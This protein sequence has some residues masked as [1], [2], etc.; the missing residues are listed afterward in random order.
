MN[1]H[2]PFRVLP[3]RQKI[4]SYFLADESDVVTSLRNMAEINADL[5]N[6]I[7]QTAKTLVE[8]VRKTQNQQGTIEA[9][10]QEY[11]L[12]TDEGTVLMCLA[13]ALLRIPDD[14]T[15]DK[16]IKDKIIPA[17][18][19]THLGQSQS[20]FVNAST[21]GLMLT[22]KILLAYPNEEK[23]WEIFN[24][25]LNRMGEPVIR[26]VLKKAMR[27]MG[28]QFVME[29]NIDKAIARSNKNFHD[30]YRFSYDMLGEAALCTRDAERYFE[31]YV[32]ALNIIGEARKNYSNNIQAP[33][34]S[35]K[36]SA[37]HPRYEVAQYERVMLELLPKIKELAILAKSLDVGLTIDA[38]EAERL[39]IS[40]DLYEAVIID[41]E[42]KPWN[43]FGLAVQAYQKRAF[44][45]LNWLKNLANETGCKI[46]VRLVK[47]A[48]WDTEIKRAQEKGL[49]NYPVF[50]RKV[51]TDI[52]YTACAKF[53]LENSDEFYPQ[54]ATHNAYT[55]ATII[56]LAKINNTSQ[57]EF[58]RLHGMGEALY[59]H[60]IDEYP[61]RVYAPVGS[62]EDLLPYLVRRLLENGAN[63]SFVNRVEN[64]DVPIE[65][66]IEDPVEKSLRQ[67]LLVNPHI[68]LP[69]DLFGESRPN[70]NGVN[71]SDYEVLNKLIQDIEQ[72]KKNWSA[73]PLI[74][75]W[76]TS[77]PVNE[78]TSPFNS[79]IIGEAEN[80]TK[81]DVEKCLNIAS[82]H[83]TAWKKS[84][85]LGRIDIIRQFAELLQTHKTEL[86]ALCIYEA[87]KTVNDAI[88]EV[89]EAID[90]CYYYVEQAENLLSNPVMLPGPTGEDNILQLH[91]RGVFVCISPWNFPLAIFTGQLI[92]AYITGNSVI[93]KPSTNTRLISHFAIRLLLKAGARPNTLFYL[94]CS[95][96]LFSELVL[97]DP[98]VAGVAFTGS[99]E[100]AWQINQTLAKRRAAIVPLIAETGG[101][102]AMIVD[103]SALAEQVV[104]DVITSAFGSAG[105]RCSALRILIVQKDVEQRIVDLLIQGMKELTVGPS[106][107]IDTDVPAVIDEIAKSKLDV[108]K[109]KMRDEN[110]LLFELPIPETLDG[111]FVNPSLF[112][113]DDLSELENEQFGPFLHVYSYEQSAL[114]ENIENINKL[115]YGLTLGIHSRI[116]ETINFI[117]EN[118]NV[119]NVY[120]NRN[121][122]GAVVG[123]QPF[124]G[125]GLSGTGPKAGGPFYLQRFCSEKTLCIN[126]SAIGGNTKLLSLSD[127]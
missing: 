118:V 9:F 4:N 121:M 99:V 81:K 93:A 104:K 91:G 5:K 25:L 56:E 11:D 33:S 101:Q 89:R 14:A 87:G 38:E 107:E 41:P 82:E 1:K 85:L 66:I 113:I 7:H 26:N 46:P 106:D 44:H 83:S 2:K 124:G 71:N 57:F 78:V 50:T 17:Q 109:N 24:K 27:I 123:V 115:G 32:S 125:E 114:A 100:T 122:I 48:Y 51:N 18:W 105:Q 102:N 65:K 74:D 62:Y 80:A 35:I 90:F 103:S 12:S 16:L 94:P 79:L 86:Y 21:W 22:G 69:C 40:L 15:A 23:P 34:L 76:N 8:N 55:L 72:I 110:K 52:S 127:S 70:S 39:D 116:D 126:T 67:N 3:V 43:G 59:G 60:I 88:A 63:T 42:L 68:P 64:E 29:T 53:M 54:F 75:D 111:H 112:R 97:T 36:L 95:A 84:D 73:K 96:K 98:R 92:A 49:A 28:T 117:A 13:E 61:C 20:L 6:Q 108:Y 58:Q 30:N 120:V 19:Q 119:G 31:S 37:L 10:I 47:G 77:N 45:V